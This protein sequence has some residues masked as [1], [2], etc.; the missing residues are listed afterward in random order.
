MSSAG[1]NLPRWPCAGYILTDGGGWKPFSDDRAAAAGDRKNG[2]REREQKSAGGEQ[3]RFFLF[4]FSFFVTPGVH[5]A[6]MWEIILE[7]A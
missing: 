1:L 5:M 2:K 6:G 3:Q 4:L 7:A